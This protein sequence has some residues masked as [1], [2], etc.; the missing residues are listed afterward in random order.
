MMKGHSNIG[1]GEVARRL[2]DEPSVVVCV[3]V[4]FPMLPFYVPPEGKAL[5]GRNRD[6]NRRLFSR[7][8][9]STKTVEKI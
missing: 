4:M 8:Y 2:R 3:C 6:E 5:Y 1:G 7:N 9:E